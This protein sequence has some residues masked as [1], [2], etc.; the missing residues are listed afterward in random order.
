[1][2]YLMTNP[3]TVPI[4]AATWT[5]AAT[6]VT[7]GAIHILE[8]GKQ[9]W[10]KRLDTGSAAPTDPTSGRPTDGVKFLDTSMEITASVPSDI[11]IFCTEGGAVQ[12]DAEGGLF[13]GGGGAAS[14]ST[15]QDWWVP[16]VLADVTNGANGTYPYYADMRG[17]TRFGLD[18]TLTGTLAVKVYVATEDTDSASVTKWTDVT[19]DLFGSATL[20][21]SGYYADNDGKTE[22]ATWIKV[23]VVASGGGTDD[24]KVE[25]NKLWR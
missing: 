9:Y 10:F 16:D 21:T 1:M 2:G 15:S 14:A 7:S 11:Y 3:A 20:T 19:N 22:N 12:Y 13:A 24:W 4:T 18:L 17:Y 25:L 23:E 5:K 6:A 8:V